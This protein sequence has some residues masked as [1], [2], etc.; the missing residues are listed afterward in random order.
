M[1]TQTKGQIKMR[2]YAK[3]RITGAEALARSL[4]EEGITLMFGY[5][6]GAIMPFYDENFSFYSV[7]F[8]FLVAP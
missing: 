1:D 2:K 3:T 6:G 4:I 8:V 7:P 5:V